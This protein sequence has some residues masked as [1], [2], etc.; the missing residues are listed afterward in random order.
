MR[1]DAR[2]GLLHSARAEKTVMKYMQAYRYLFESPK[3]GMNLLWAV[4]SQFVPVIGAIVCL[5]Y[6]FD[7]IETLHRRKDSRY[8]DIDMNRLGEYLMRGL[9]VFLVQ[10]VASLPFAL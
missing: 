1:P 2:F 10:L 8:P 7:M 5:G 4:L 3:W 6:G 9:W